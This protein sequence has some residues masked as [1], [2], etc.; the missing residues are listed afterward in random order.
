V[1]ILH[2]Y[3]IERNLHIQRARLITPD[4]ETQLHFIRLR[5]KVNIWLRSSRPLTQQLILKIAVNKLSIYV[6]TEKPHW[7]L[8]NNYRLVQKL[9]R[10]QKRKKSEF[11]R[12]FQS[13]NYTVPEVVTTKLKVSPRLDKTISNYITDDISQQNFTQSIVCFTQIPY[14]IVLKLV[15]FVIIFLRLHRIPWQ[16]HEF[17]MFR[18]ISETAFQVCGHPALYFWP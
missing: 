1:S 4:S 7:Q 14:S 2:W 17:S 9:G 8:I 3:R 5:G 15:L 10:V 11:S 13:H 18:K 12:L 16:F 6:S